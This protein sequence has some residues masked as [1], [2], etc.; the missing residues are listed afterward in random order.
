MDGQLCFG[1]IF[2]YYDNLINQR[3]PSLFD[4]IWIYIVFYFLSF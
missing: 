1:I 3:N 4:F 2:W